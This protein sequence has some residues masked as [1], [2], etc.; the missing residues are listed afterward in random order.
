V[1]DKPKLAYI[2]HS[3][4]TTQAF[5]ALSINQEYF[6]KRWSI[7][8]ALAPPINLKGFTDYPLF[9]FLTDERTT[10]LISTTMKNLN[11]Y[12]ISQANII[13]SGFIRTGCLLV[14]DACKLMEFMLADSNPDINSVIAVQTYFGHYPSGSSL[15]ELEHFT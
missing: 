14:P 2:G 3:M 1:T 8:V 4:G 11:L 12:E 7:F 13:S 10:T 5:Y 15:K 9:R 6:K